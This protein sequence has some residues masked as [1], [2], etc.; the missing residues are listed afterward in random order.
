[1]T[2]DRKRMKLLETAVKKVTKE[3]INTKLR[4]KYDTHVQFGG[5]SVEPKT[6]K[7]VAIYGGKNALEHYTNNADYTGVQ[8]GSTFKPFVLAAAMK[9]GVRDKDGDRDQPDSTR[10]PVSPTSVYDGDNKLTLRDYNG[11]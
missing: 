7:I 9:D 4:P 5:A 1:T 2:F 6:G 10:T 3:N 8:V 11:T